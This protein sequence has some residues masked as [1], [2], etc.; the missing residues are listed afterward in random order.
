M[1]KP[2][3][4][5]YACIL[6]LYGYSQD[7]ITVLTHNVL[8][9]SGHPIEI[10]HT[11]SIIL[12]NAIAFYREINPDI[13]I[14]Q[15]CPAIENVKKLADSL[16]YDFEFF[17]PRFQGNDQYPYGF[18]GCVMTRFPIIESYD[19]LN[20]REGIPDSIFERHFGMVKLET[21]NGTIQ[22]TGLHLC[23]DF[24]GKFR[25]GTRL[26]EID[27]ALTKIITCDTCFLNILAGDFNSKP[28]SL[29]YNFILENG[30]KDTHFDANYATVPIPN[31]TVRID[32]IFVKSRRQVRFFPIKLELPYYRESDS[33]LSDHLPLLTKFI[34]Y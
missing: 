30:Y 27:L 29:P 28:F 17:K 13:I 24:N 11:D 21:E 14:L 12:Q 18:P 22:V 8:A 26:R 25:E 2:F 20:D 5:F 15:E 9:F 31:P 32:Y 16:L 4:F 23:A 1:K 3:L 34:V 6:S 33:Y 10:H 7:T 19:F